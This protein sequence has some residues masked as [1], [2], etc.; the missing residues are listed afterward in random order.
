MAGVVLPARRGFTAACRADSSSG[1]T[2]SPPFVQTFAIASGAKG[3]LQIAQHCVNGAIN[4]EFG[5]LSVH[6]V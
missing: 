5:A 3:V 2:R 6:Y 1:A 4:K